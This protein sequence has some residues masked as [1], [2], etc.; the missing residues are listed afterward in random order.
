MFDSY[1]A[2]VGRAHY[3]IVVAGQLDPAWAEWFG[4]FAISCPTPDASLLDG[5]VVDQSA[6]YG[7]LGRLHDFNLALLSV[8]RLDTQPLEGSTP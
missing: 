2:N 4:D 5:H 8:L 6:L 7:L 1:P 3:Q